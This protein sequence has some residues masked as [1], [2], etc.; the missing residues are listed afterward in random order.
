MSD[1]GARFK[2]HFSGHASDYASHRPTYPPELFE[3]LASKSFG[4]ELAWDC[5]TGSGQAALALATHFRQVVATDA[6]P[7]QLEQAPAHERV[8][9]RVETSE[10]SRCQSSSVDLLTVAQAYHWFDREAFHKE[11]GR[12]LKAG[13]L[14]AVWTYPLAEINPVIDELVYDLWDRQ[15]AGFWPPERDYVDR[16]YRDFDMPWPELSVPAMEMTASWTLENLLGYLGTW[17]G[18]KRFEKERGINPIDPMRG[19]FE[20]AWGDPNLARKVRWPLILRACRKS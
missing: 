5:A 8:T 19:A 1:Q 14:F 9:Y 17:S 13:G 2:D 11:A 3:W 15:L 12:V 7:Q 4:H 6:S 10:A 16:H 18:L 20:A